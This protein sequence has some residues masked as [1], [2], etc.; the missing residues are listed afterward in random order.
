MTIL[1]IS[2]MTSSVFDV[3][4]SLTLSP[5]DNS[6]L[7]SSFTNFITPEFK[8]RNPVHSFSDAGNNSLDIDFMSDL[9]DNE[10]LAPVPVEPSVESN[11][12]AGSGPGSANPSDHPLLDFFFSPVQAAERTDEDNSLS[13][14]EPGSAHPGL[15]SS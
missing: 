8:T 2:L 12:L 4:S 10:T 7:G 14:S 13:G 3:N 9:T 6:L 5:L 11:L 15:S 1:P